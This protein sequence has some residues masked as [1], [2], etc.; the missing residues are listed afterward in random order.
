M[1]KTV[2]VKGAQVSFQIDGSGP[3]LVLVH[4]TGGNAKSHWG[5]LVDK[6]SEHWTVIRPDFSGSGETVDS[7]EELSIELLAE[8]VVATAKAV[9]KVPFDLVGFSLGAAVAAYIAAEHPDEVHSVVLLAGFASG[10]DSRMQLQCELWRDLAKTDPHAMV[11]MLLLT[12]FSAQTFNELGIK[13]IKNNVEVMVH[14]V[15]WEGLIRQLDMVLS[16]DIQDKLIKIKC[17][18]LVIGCL[19]DQM[20]PIAHTKALAAAIS[21]ACYMEFPSGHFAPMECPD[22]FVKAT[23]DFLLK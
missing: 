1:K 8:Q 12:G 19:D 14:G 9:G 11:R 10:L 16:L 13:Q 20:A 17:P 22:L 23:K 5:H 7:G 15:D 3:G 21:G 18:V 4:G 2:V 6:F